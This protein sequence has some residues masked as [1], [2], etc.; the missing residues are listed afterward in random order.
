MDEGHDVLALAMG[1]LL[2]LQGVLDPAKAIPGLGASVSESLAL[3]YLATGPSTQQDLGTYLGLEKS[4]VSRL[5]SA[6]VD[7][8]WVDKTR[9]GGG[10]R[11]YLVT[12]TPGGRQIAEQITEAMRVQHRQWLDALTPEERHAL[13]VGLT[14]LVRVMADHAN[15]D[16]RGRRHG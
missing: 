14:A 5:V 7:K 8:G 16:E 9:A 13:T 12:L 2:R 11:H 15:L 6:M 4:T 10:R 1:R 3:G